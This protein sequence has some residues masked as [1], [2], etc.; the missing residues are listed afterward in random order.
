MLNILLLSPIQSHKTADVAEHLK[1][2]I[3][4]RGCPCGIHVTYHQLHGLYV[5]CHELQVSCQIGQFYVTTGFRKY[6][7]LG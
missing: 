7:K 2:N 3:Y 6:I 1:K 4:M 5:L